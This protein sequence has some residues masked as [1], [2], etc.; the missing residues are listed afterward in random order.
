MQAMNEDVLTSLL[1]G[2]V[3]KAVEDYRGGYTHPN[4]P[5]AAAFLVSAGLLVDG[6]LDARFGTV[7][8]TRTGR[9]SHAAAQ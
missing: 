2:I 3:L 7:A 8:R 5:D 4:K 6:H 1:A 9:R